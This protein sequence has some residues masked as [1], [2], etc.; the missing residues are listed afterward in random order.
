MAN[1]VE[2]LVKIEPSLSKLKYIISNSL[3]GNYWRALS[4]KGKYGK[5]LGEGIRIATTSPTDV[6]SQ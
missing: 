1:D 3:A 2:I 6:T 4:P 5:R